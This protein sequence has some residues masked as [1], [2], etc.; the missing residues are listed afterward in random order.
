[1]PPKADGEDLGEVSPAEFLLRIVWPSKLHDGLSALH[2]GGRSGIVSFL[3]K[4]QDGASHCQC[5]AAT[6][7]TVE[8]PSIHPF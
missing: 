6:A 4:G 8:L 7:A 3:G 5:C 2:C 1:M